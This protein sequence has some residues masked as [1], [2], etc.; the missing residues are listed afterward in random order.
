LMPNSINSEGST[1]F[2]VDQPLQISDA[3]SLS[4]GRT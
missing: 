3:T 4:I 2:A 1:V